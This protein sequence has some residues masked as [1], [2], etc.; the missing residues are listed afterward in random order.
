MH[1]RG[2][3]FDM[4]GTL[5]DTL[6]VCIAAFQHVFEPRLG[7]RVS[8][9]EVLGMFGPSEEG[10]IRRLI[11]DGY[12]P[13]VQEYLA[14]YERLHAEREI[15]IP[16]IERALAL[17]RDRGILL[18]VVTGKG[19]ASAA[20]SFRHL[21]LAPYF[22]V[23]EAGSPDG[24]VKPERIRRVL[25]RWGFPP[26]E[27]AYVGDSPSDIADA[28]S[29]GV[30]PLAAGWA[31]TSAVQDPACCGARITFE[32]VERFCEWIEGWDAGNEATEAQRAQREEGKRGR[33]TPDPGPLAH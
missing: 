24:G 9:E 4:D 29:V 20:I 15:A 13:A 14:E 8:P 19:A 23:V 26:G 7:R 31:A 22:D 16:G 28:A 33:G 10:M 11:P 12:E 25:A 5:C 27:V 3:I 18:G 2:M 30:I 21:G 1:L 32:S 6:P 17:L